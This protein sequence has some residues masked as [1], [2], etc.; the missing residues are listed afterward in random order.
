LVFLNPE[1][2]YQ[3]KGGKI[4]CGFIATIGFD[5][6]D[7]D[8]NIISNLL[9]HRGPDS[10]SIHSSKILNTKVFF[11]RL[12]INDISYKGNMPFFIKNKKISMVANCEIY[13]FK[14]I[15]NFLL[16]KNIKFSSSSDAEVIIKGY[17]YWGDDIFKKIEGM[18]TIFLIDEINEKIFIARDSLG[19]KPLFFFKHNKKYIFSS[20]FLPIIK[21]KKLLGYKNN[22]KKNF[23]KNSNI[24]N[25]T[26]ET[27]VENIFKF[28]SGYLSTLSK[29][30]LS[31]KKIYKPNFNQSYLSYEEKVNKF[32]LLLENSIKTHL[33]SDR[34]VSVL[35]SGGIDSSLIAVMAKKINNDIDTYSINLENSLNNDD[36]Q[37]IKLISKKFG[38]KNKTIN[39]KYSEIMN[40]IESF[41]NVYDDLSSFDGG[42]ITNYLLTKKIKNDSKVLLVGDGADELLAGYSWFGLG[43]FPFTLFPQMIRRNI[44]NYI[45]CGNFFANKEF[46]NHFEKHNSIDHLSF[47]NKIRFFEM[48]KQLP[49]NYLA[50]VDRSSMLN[51]IEARVP[52]LD[53]KLVDFCTQLSSKDLINGNTYNYNSFKKPVEKRILRDFAKKILPEE[54]INKKKKGFSLSPKK[55]LFSNL[56]KVERT[57]FDKNSFSNNYLNFDEKKK[58]YNYFINKQ[59]GASIKLCENI[60]WKTFI[61]DIWY[62]K[63]KYYFV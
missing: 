29:L 39:I 45:I 52:Y 7:K 35:L 6:N 17:Q 33:I 41:V 56:K 46:I 57:I 60:I 28:E 54:I 23:L 19:I 43:I 1:I 5:I 37:S 13:N 62:K 4:L 42:F 61:S 16:R 53:Q 12:A 40:N 55:I 9:D 18:Y 30:K 50:K 32:G 59:D 10:S 20:E 8:I 27:F 38:I 2:Q 36:I 11:N 48:F 26:S 44:I 49:N 14:E 25:Y 22:K 51:S 58:Y 34:P 21:I 15:K 24:Y 47:F 63:F 3:K 31:K